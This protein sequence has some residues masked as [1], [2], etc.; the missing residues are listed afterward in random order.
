M[1]RNENKK[2]KSSKL[3]RILGIFAI[4]LIVAAMSL[5]GWRLWQLGLQTTTE[6]DVRSLYNPDATNTPTPDATATAYLRPG[7]PTPAPTAT[8][9][10]FVI[11]KFQQLVETNPDTVGWLRIPNTNIDHVVMQGDDNYYYLDH[12]FFE[13]KATAGSMTLDFRVDI[14][15]LS[16]NV[17]LYGHHMQVGSML[18]SLEKYRNEKFYINNPILYFDTIYE[19]AQWEV[20]SAYVQSNR[21]NFFKTD[22]ETRD[23]YFKYIKALQRESIYETGIE[24]SPD[25]IILTLSTCV[26][27]FEDARMVVHARRKNL[28]PDENYD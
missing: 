6:K 8:P 25:D 12:T 26:Y 4:L 15:D 19:E 16:G 27:D 23:Y 5:L 11:P 22:F 7:E 13:D 1:K 14:A 28:I 9:Q 2:K 24:L 10:P 20:F 21:F 3:S 18:N 17:L